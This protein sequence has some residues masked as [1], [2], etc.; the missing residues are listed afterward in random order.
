MSG[1]VSVPNQFVAAVTATGQQ[2]DT[3]FATL[4]AYSNDPTNRNN[5]G[6]DTGTGGTYTVTINPPA[7]GYTAGL[8]VQWQAV[9]AS[10]AN[11]QVNISGIGS[12]PIQDQ[13]GVAIAA[14]GIIAGGLVSGVVKGGTSFVLINNNV[15]VPLAATQA[16]METATAT[17]SFVS[18]A[19]AKFHPGVAK[20]WAVFNG[21][22]TGT[23]TAG[24][25]FMPVAYNVATMARVGTG[26]YTVNFVTG[27]STTNYAVI[28]SNPT[29]VNT[30]AIFLCAGLGN[31][32]TGGF[33]LDGRNFSAGTP[34][35][36]IRGSFV[37]YGD[38]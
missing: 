22:A 7:L 17:A 20:A 32:G 15:P 4:A 27:M 24:G 9:N 2:L 37:V 38:L 29:Q 28:T 23:I 25:A 1:T 35:D 10:S 16:E 5:F 31:N 26:T 30:Q 8:F 13:S 12:L 33:G 3:N 36:I 18:P 19:V 6:V 11:A 21:T 34:V 14:N